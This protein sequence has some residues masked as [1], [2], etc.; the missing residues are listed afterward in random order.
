GVDPQSGGRIGASIRGGLPPDVGGEAPPAAPMGRAIQ[1]PP[2]R[3][4]S[5]RA[6]PMG[7]GRAAGAPLRQSAAAG[8]AG[9]RARFAAGAP[10]R[11]CGSRPPPPPRPVPPSA[12]PLPPPSHPPSPA[13]REAA[14]AAE[15]HSQLDAAP[16]DAL[17]VAAEEVGGAPWAEKSVH[18]GDAQ[19]PAP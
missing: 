15:H 4:P 19:A 2:E 9:E 13:A 14:A 16:E 7:R 10:A 12:R 11:R 5:G 18:A 3:G 6:A 8:A 17:G 1:S